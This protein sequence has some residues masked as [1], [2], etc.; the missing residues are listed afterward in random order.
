MANSKMVQ[1]DYWYE[2]A[3][4]LELLC[5]YIKDN[6]IKNVKYIELYV[7]LE[8]FDYRKLFLSQIN[9]INNALKKK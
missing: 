7:R 1:P 2:E 5:L 6:N 4:I 9:M 3:Q 8:L